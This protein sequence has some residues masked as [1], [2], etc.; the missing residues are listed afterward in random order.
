M[1]IL[2]FQKPPTPPGGPE[3]DRLTLPSEGRGSRD[4]WTKELDAAT[5]RI[6]PL[7][8]EWD[9]NVLDYRA[10]TL[11]STPLTHSV[12]VPRSFSFV[13]Q[14]ISQLF[15]QLPDV[16]LT[17]LQDGLDD[18]VP[19]F[20]ARLNQALGEDE[21][22]SLATMDEVLFDALCPSGLMCSV[23]GYENFQQGTSEI[24]TG[25]EPDPDAAMGPSLGQPDPTQLPGSILGIGTPAPAPPMIPTMATVPNYVYQRYFFTRLSPPSILIPQG[26]SGSVYD[27]APWLGYRAED[28]W[29]LLKVRYQLPP[30]MAKPS[31][32]N[33]DDEK[34]KLPGEPT[35]QTSSRVATDKVAYTVIWV[36]ASYV[37]PAEVHPE[38]FRELVLADGMDTPLVY[39]NSKFQK[40]NTQGELVGLAGNP[41][42]IGALRYVSDSAFPPSE[43][44]VG[45]STS[46]ELNVS[47]TQMLLS[48]DRSRPMRFADL[49]KIGGETGLEKLRK[50][51]DQAIIP[52]ESFDANNPPVSAVGLAAYPQQ[53]FAF[54]QILDRDQDSLWAMG[55]NQRGQQN[56]GRTS[57]TEINKIDQWAETRLDKERRRALRYYL[58]AVRKIAALIQLFDDDTDY[59]RVVGPDKVARLQ[60]WDRQTI[61][62]KYAFTANP[63]SALR[64]DQAQKITQGL[65]RYELWAKDPNVN[66]VELLEECCKDA[67]LDPKKLIIPQLPPKGPDQPNISIRL[68]AEALDIRNPNFPIYLAMLKTAGYKNLFEPDPATGMTPIDEAFEYGKYQASIVASAHTG[69]AAQGLMPRITGGVGGNGRLPEHG[70]TAPTADHVNKHTADL[71]GEDD[72]RPPLLGSNAG[73]M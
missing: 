50:N 38:T 36:R 27:R 16:H 59:V 39:R 66:R 65:K 20:Q 46:E 8:A 31:S 35:Q 58:G 41:I 22:N 54:Q 67:D 43:C 25:E 21:I 33:I 40:R 53:D 68:D 14:K 9:E 29:A 73:V 1:A 37:D 69:V 71:T 64:L 23:I 24:Q 45:R 42:H 15:F 48:R 72:G 60:S 34:L 47:R 4:F 63:N 28:D 11:K 2:P 51:I 3:S 44:S 26:W 10:K 62:G 30:D 18:A 56:Q 61:Q 12:V 70:G 6:D 7:K 17:S 19:V 55:A 13:E 32:K 52:L 5:E 57:A 49:G